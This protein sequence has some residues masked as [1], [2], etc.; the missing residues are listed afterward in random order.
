[1]NEAEYFKYWGKARPAS[2]DGAA[3]HL[4]AYHC[5]DVAAVGAVFLSR[6]PQLVSALSEPLGLRSGVFRAWSVYFLALHDIGKFAQSFQRQAESV[7][8]NLQ[9]KT[10]TKVSG[11]RHDTLGYVLWREHVWP[12]VI[13]PNDPFGLGESLLDCKESLG[14]WAECVTGHH[15]KPP[16]KSNHSLSE[17]FTTADREAAAHFI[18]HLDFLLPKSGLSGIDDEQFEW[19]MRSVSWWLAGI[20]VLSDWLG[21]N[22]DYFPYE[23]NASVGLE[24][25]WQ[26]ALELAE[27]A[28][29]ESHTLPAAPG[30]ARDIL[31]LLPTLAEPTE[32]QNLAHSLPL[33]TDPQI[34]IL[35]DLTGSGKTEAAVML[36]HR[37]MQ[38][39]DADGV[40][41]ALPTMATANA[42]YKRIREFHRLLFAL[43]EQASLVLAHSQ[44]RLV[45]EFSASVLMVQQ[46]PEEAA[47]KESG[48]ETASAYCAAWLADNTKKALLASLGV[49]TIDQVLMSILHSKHQS[50][51][52]LGLFRKVLIVDEVHANDSYVHRLLCVVLR[53]HAAAGGSAVLLSA[54]LPQAMRAQLLEAFALGR[55]EKSIPPLVENTYPL[56]TRWSLEGVTTH[57][58]EAPERARR[59]VA[60]SFIRAPEEATKLIVDAANAGHCVCWIRNT[61]NDA[62]A[63]YDELRGVLG[64]QVTLFHA[65]FMMGDRLDIEQVVLARFGKE[66]T[67][68]GRSGQV[69]VATQVVEQSLDL[70]F[71][72]MISDLAPIDL[73]IQRAGRL[74]RHPRNKQGEL[75]MDSLDERSAPMLHVLSPQPQEAADE[76]WLKALLPGTAAVYPDHAVL[77]RTAKLMADCGAIRMPVDARTLIEG[78]YGDEAIPVPEAL[79]NAAQQVEGKHSADKSVAT[80]NSLDFEEGYRAGSQRWYQE[81]HTPTRLGEPTS[82]LCLLAWDGQRLRPLYQEAAEFALQMSQVS[83]RRWLVAEE[84]VPSDIVLSQALERYKQERPYLKKWLVLVPM[85]QDGGQAWYGTALDERGRTV[86]L[87]YENANGLGI[88][89]RDV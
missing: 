1:M 8:A 63:S 32:L 16:E 2:E 24:A 18:E 25:Y 68:A 62:T 84:A 36:A 58:V 43:P 80:Y 41:F 14:I 21:S 31:E 65:R 82:K 37:L 47:S 28:I 49:G 6:H 72:V 3:C 17:S 74:H 20:A 12:Q 81:A 45:A 69:L 33:S 54:T 85:A 34:F 7:F 87:Q 70:D 44:R 27:V 15:G 64:D 40:F 60:V 48:E 61:V 59:D 89:R 22:R 13:N 75:Q 56:L 53:F 26:R 50:M 78:V 57:P 9:N 29:A 73:L 5:L 19:A 88:T 66:S 46:P 30:P 10:P 71:D 23:D 52:L 76:N 38:Q 35:E 77:W 86:T 39:G 11:T 42:M 4:L 55:N 51:R 79:V 67:S 83:I